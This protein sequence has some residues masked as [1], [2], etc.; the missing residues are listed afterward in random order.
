MRIAL[1]VSAYAPAVGGVENHVR[2]LA[3]GLAARDDVT[4]V[5]HLLDP[6]HP[7]AESDDGVEIRRFPLTVSATNYRYS[8][9]LGRFLRRDGKDFDVVHVH[10]YHTLVGVNALLAGVDPL[11]F[12]PHYHGTGHTKFR[13]LLHKPYR[14]VGERVIRRCRAIVCVSR[15]EAA[16]VSADFPGSAGRVVVIPNGTSPSHP[17]TDALRSS[18]AGPS[19]VVSVGRLET[20]KRTDLLIRAVASLPPPTRVIVIGDGPARPHLENLVHDLRLDDRVVLAGRLPQETVNAALGGTGVVASMS[21]HEA[22]G[23]SVADGLAAGAR[24]VASDLPAHR[25]VAAL[26]GRPDLVTL[27]PGGDPEALARAVGAALRAGRPPH[28]AR[29]PSWDDVV[30]Q[31]RDVYAEVGAA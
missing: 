24:V 20:Y 1:V 15:A 8:T 21:E 25:E 4:V 7:P 19:D 12:T 9:A 22:F 14:F 3:T 30:R 11:V 27:V 28:P 10:S 5:T 23:L 31:T 6:K 2:Q 26:G 16:Q 13:A 18:P 29:L 17:S